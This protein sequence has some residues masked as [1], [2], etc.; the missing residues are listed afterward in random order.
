MKL[1]RCV[2][3]ASPERNVHVIFTTLEVGLYC[4]LIFMRSK[5]RWELIN[6][7]ECI[8]GNAL[9]LST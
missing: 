2:L 1:T 3:L 6:I 8:L 7:Q 5:E 9:F 4:D